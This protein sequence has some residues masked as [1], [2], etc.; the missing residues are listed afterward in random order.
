ML[1]QHIIQAN[2]QK[3]QAEHQFKLKYLTELLDR[4]GIDI[5]VVIDK[6][7]DFQEIG[8]AS[9]RERV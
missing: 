2:N 3:L 7:K 6:I 5:Q 9:C 1:N 4:K 8:R